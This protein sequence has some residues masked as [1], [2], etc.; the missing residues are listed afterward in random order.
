MNRESQLAVI[1]CA[2]VGTETLLAQDIHPAEEISLYETHSKKKGT[3]IQVGDI[4]TLEGGFGKS[5]L[6]G[7]LTIGL[8][9]DAQWKVTEDDPGELQP[10]FDVYGVG[11]EATLPMATKEHA[12]RLHHDSLHVGFR[13]SQYVRGGLL[14]ASGDLPRSE[15]GAAIGPYETSVSRT[16]K[17]KKGFND[18]SKVP[19]SLVSI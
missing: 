4:V 13:R 7:A 8:A 11:V 19:D 9:F 5:F 6:E 2:G 18:F 14:R 17:L 12:D 10:I 1:L 16:R 3:Y 15:Y